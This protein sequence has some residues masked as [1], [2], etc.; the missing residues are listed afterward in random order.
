MPLKKGSSQKTISANI[1]ELHAENVKKKKKGEKPRPHKQIVAIA[2]NKAG[3]KKKLNESMVAFIE[4]FSA[5]YPL[6]TKY[7]I[8][9]F[10]ACFEN[11][12]ENEN[13]KSLKI[14]IPDDAS[15]DDINKIQSVASI[16]LNKAKETAETKKRLD[17][18]MNRVK[19][20]LHKT[21]EEI[22]RN[23]A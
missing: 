16:A 5:E 10:N 2:L 22:S 13:D 20:S 23:N 19:E 18:E 4:S 14:K 1:S 21:S 11:E 8:E 9:A 7:I 6:E 15:P 12:M 3:K 17:D